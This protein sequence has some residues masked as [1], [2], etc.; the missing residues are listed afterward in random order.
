MS[1]SNQVF[2]PQG[3]ATTFVEFVFD[4]DGTYS[5]STADSMGK[6]L[7]ISVFQNG[8]VLTRGTLPNGSY[9]NNSGPYGPAGSAQDPSWFQL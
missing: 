7:Q 2:G 4:P 9:T 3:A 8:R 1:S 6:S 5:G